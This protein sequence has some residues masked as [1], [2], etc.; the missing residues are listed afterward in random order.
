MA[1]VR[2]IA[3]ARHELNSIRNRLQEELGFAFSFKFTSDKKTAARAIANADVRN[4]ISSLQ[5][6]DIAIQKQLNSISSWF[7]HP[8]IVQIH[9]GKSLLYLPK[10]TPLHRKARELSDIFFARFSKKR[11]LKLEQQVREGLAVSFQAE[12]LNETERAKLFNTKFAN[13]H[14]A[15][16]MNLAKEIWK[17]ASSNPKLR[18]EMRLEILEKN[19]E[20]ASEA[21]HY[22]MEKYRH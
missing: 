3:S 12:F 4:K 7:N 1:N 20:T 22:L 13:P 9:G 5:N 16:G 6:R 14:V 21:I 2:R 11:G 15:L 10:E 19:F 8:K 17:M 18:A